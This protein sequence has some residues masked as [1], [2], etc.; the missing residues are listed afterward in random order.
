MISACMFQRGYMLA[1]KQALID[2][3]QIPR[4]DLSLY[5]STITQ[6]AI[7]QALNRSVPNTARGMI[8]VRIF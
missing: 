5:V 7:K 4:Y 6:L 1:I 8:S 3:C 2:L